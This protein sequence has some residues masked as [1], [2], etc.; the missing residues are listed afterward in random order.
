MANLIR[1]QLQE[2]EPMR[3]MREMM[4]WEPFRTWALPH[5]LEQLSEWAPDFEV[6]ENGDRF[7]IRGDVP[8]VA[9]KD[10]EVTLSGNVL[11]IAGKREEEKKEEND[12]FYAYER[13]YGAFSRS[14][15]LPDGA[16]G[17]HIATELKDGVLTLALPKT[18]KVPTKKIEIKAG[19]PIG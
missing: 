19:K 4:H 7:I 13:C 11:T 9:D 6:K 2:W 1:K 15:V 10:L 17:E 14:F 12:K 5:R 8:G 16:D 3:M 18:T